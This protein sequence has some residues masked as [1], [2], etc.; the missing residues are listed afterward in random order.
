MAHTLFHHLFIAFRAVLKGVVLL[1]VWMAVALT[2][3]FFWSQFP[4]PANFVL[5]VPLIL[6]G[7]TM[8][9]QA[10]YETVVGIISWRWGRTHC[11]FCEPPK[12]VKKILS[13]FDGFR[14]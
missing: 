8:G 5:G 11:P 3:I 12:E 13:P 9:L 1:A 2:G 4:S 14:D 10:F 7:L 6:I